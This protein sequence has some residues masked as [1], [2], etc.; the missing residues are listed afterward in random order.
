MAIIKCPECGHEISDKAP[1]CPSCGVA[2]AGKVR[3]CPVCGK[4]YFAEQPECPQ[5]HNKTTEDNEVK[6]VTGDVAAAIVGGSI[7]HHLST[8]NTDTSDAETANVGANP[9]SRRNNVVVAI[10][11]VAVALLVGGICWYFS[12][13]TS[14]DR[15][16][17][18]YEYAMSSTDPQ[19][20]QKY[21]DTYLDDAPSEHI[22]AIED[23]LA[24]LKQVDADWTNAV[25]SGSKNALEQYLAQHPDSPFK[26]LALH[27]IDSIDWA[28]ASAS[29]N[30]EALEAYLEQH[31]D[32]EHVEDA[33]MM[34]KDLNSKTLQP[35]EKLMIGGV[36][37]SFFNSLNNRDED[38][39][40]SAVNPLL[41]SFLGKPN[42]TRND[43]VTFMHKIYKSDVSSMT[44]T[45]NG[46]YN[47]NKKEVGD[48]KYEYSVNFSAKQTVNYTDNPTADVKYRIT[49][50][51]NPE[52]RISEFNMVKIV[53]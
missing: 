44:W 10:V 43:V 16:N 47:I 22:Q 46:D 51:I 4:A 2:I 42:A 32:G 37:D 52:G 39:L 18:A 38:A 40:T 33:N 35:E 3:V 41:S 9:T 19:V 29:N 7:A 31:S 27:K 53:N 28:A 36:F 13:K 20:V 49:A 21:L 1:F 25:V 12:C 30:V 45:S 17:Q 26:A 50:K 14:A 11:A 8:Q 15:E 23:H 24:A 5:C 34:I 48:E 6:N